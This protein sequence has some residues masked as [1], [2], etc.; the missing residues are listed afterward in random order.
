MFT[1]GKTDYHTRNSASAED[2]PRNFTHFRFTSAALC[3]GFKYSCR[4]EPSTMEANSSSA[5]NSTSG[6]LGEHTMHCHPFPNVQF[7]ASVNSLPYFV[8]AALNVPL[9]VGTTVANLLV[10]LAMRHVTSI[11]LPSKLLL[12]SLVVTDLGAGSVVQPQFAAFLFLRAINPDLVPCALY[13]SYSYTGSTFS[14]ASLWTLAAISLDRYAALFFHLKYQQIM[15]TRRVCAVLAFIWVNSLIW[16]PLLLLE[17][18]IFIVV[19]T[20][21]LVALLVIS[22]ACIKILRRLRAPHIQPQAPDQEQQ[23][24]GNTLNMERYRRIASAQMVV[25]M[26]VMICYLPLSCM[27]AL[28]SMAKTTALTLCLYEYSY[29]FVLLN[30]FLNPFVYCLR[31]PEIR[32][33]VVKQLRKLFFQRSSTQ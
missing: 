30:S 1:G 5:P 25:H 7:E 12:C 6:S 24:A 14:A 9:A 11:R 10:L 8:N 29:S 15:T 17:G 3:G 27:A 16:P 2:T 20:C 4:R 18:K 31:L 33:E 28:R 22:V 21:P 23:Q 13:I 26:L 32:T 19:V